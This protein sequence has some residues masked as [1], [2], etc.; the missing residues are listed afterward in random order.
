M[1]R[2]HF[3]LLALAFLV[4][5]GT[6]DKG[7]GSVTVSAY[8]ES[9]IE[10]GI[11][12]TDVDDGW[13]VE[14]TRFEVRLRDV[15]VA[16]IPIGISESIDLARPSSGAGHIL[17]SA[18]VPA[19]KHTGSSYTIAHVELEG[20]AVKGETIK[21]FHWVFDRPTHYSDCETTSEVLADQ[22]TSFQIT[23]HA[24]HLLYDSL[25][26][27]DPQLLFQALADADAN[28]D[29]SIT[30]AELAA[31]DIGA[32]DPGSESGTNDLWA[33]LSAL[34]ATLGHVDGEG[35]CHAAFAP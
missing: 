27:D 15:T 26:A 2:S 20:R 18:R 28:N 25:V 1:L 21:T 14:F 34:V 23:V 9:F 11:P 13:A 10:D 5:C 7:D 33:Y 32:Y 31:T 8:G 6:E 35:H 12:A 24:D 29:G 19:G 4:A 17:G 30:Q 22:S 3:G 16:G